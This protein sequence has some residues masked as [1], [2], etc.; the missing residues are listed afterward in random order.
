MIYDYPPEDDP[1]KQGDI[2]CGIPCIELPKENIPVV[3]EEETEERVR[4]ISWRDFTESGDAVT[5]IVGIRPVTAIVGT[6]NC[7]AS[8]ERDITLFEIRVFQEVEGRSKDTKSTKGWISLI[9]RQARVNQK[10]FYLPPELKIG[11]SDR[12]GVDFRAAIRIPRTTLEGLRKCRMAHLK[13]VAEE[14][15]RERL[16]EFFRRYPY[17]EWYPFTTEEFEIYSSSQND[18]SIKPFPWQIK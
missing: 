3:E 10:W 9:T 4:V 15:F 17:D 6:Q 1:I 14:H 18:A 16:A 5:A 8:R 2:F 7:D 12:M 13:L 11:F